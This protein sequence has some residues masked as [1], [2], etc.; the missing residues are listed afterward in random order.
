MTIAYYGFRSL[1]NNNYYCYHSNKGIQYTPTRATAHVLMDVNAAH[2]TCNEL[3]QM[4]KKDS[5]TVEELWTVPDYWDASSSSPPW[6]SASAERN[7]RKIAAQQGTDIGEQGV[8]QAM[9][10]LDKVNKQ[11]KYDPA[12]MTNGQTV[13]VNG[14][15]NSTNGSYQVVGINIPTTTSV[16]YELPN[17][18]AAQKDH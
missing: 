5:F 2:I 16:Q 3:N 8:K 17:I 6:E 4:T 12:W 14:P 18:T 9:D 11:V 10:G 13:F 1:Q 7:L 15:D